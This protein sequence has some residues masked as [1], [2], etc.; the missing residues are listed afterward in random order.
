MITELLDSMGCISDPTIEDTSKSGFITEDPDTE[1][2][3]EDIPLI[4]SG[5]LDI[6]NII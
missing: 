5:I 3:Q 6:N 2:I 4:I 1:G